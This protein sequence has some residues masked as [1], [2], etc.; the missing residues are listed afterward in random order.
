MGALT[1]VGMFSG[2]AC[3]IFKVKYYKRCL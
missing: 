1:I 2:T 3:S